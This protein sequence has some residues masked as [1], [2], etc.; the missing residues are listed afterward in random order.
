MFLAWASLNKV[1]SDYFQLWP[2]VGFLSRVSESS[3]PGV[4]P[5][6]TDLAIGVAI[7]LCAGAASH[8]VGVC[9]ICSSCIERCPSLDGLV[10]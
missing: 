10:I 1:H 2:K 5:R 8:T 4:V 6:R 9:G 3:G 7:E